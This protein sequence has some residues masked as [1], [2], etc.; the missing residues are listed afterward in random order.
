MRTTPVL[1]IPLFRSENQ[2]A[3]LSALFL[4]EKKCSVQDLSSNLE[5]P[6]PTVHREIGRLLKSGLI[7][8]EKIGNYRYFEP[9]HLSP[10][11]SPVRDLLLVVSGPVPLLRQELIH[12]PRIE[13][14]ALFGSWAHRLLG[15]EGTIPHDVDVLVVGNPDV[16]QVNKAC[17]LV[18]KKLGWEVNPVILTRDEWAQDTPFLRQVRSDGL[19]P[20]LGEIEERI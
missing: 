7:A 9:N 12:I 6:Y 10:F 15:K 1:P 14:A 4:S 19:V 13:W 5:I 18:G 8:E 3:L 11:F 17:S 20:I 16:R 2:A